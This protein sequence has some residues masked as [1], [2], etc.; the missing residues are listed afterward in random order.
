[1]VNKQTIYIAR[2]AVVDWL[3]KLWFYVPVDT[4][5]Y[6]LQFY[7]FNF[8]HALRILRNNEIETINTSR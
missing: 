6:K 2:I 7:A 1:M 5:K 8:W 4:V 3:I